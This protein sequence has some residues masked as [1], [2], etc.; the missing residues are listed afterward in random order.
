MTTSWATAHPPRGRHEGVLHR[1]GRD[2]RA[3]RHPSR[4]Q[5]AA[6][7]S[8]I[9][10]PSGCGKSTLLSILGL[11]DSPTERQLHA[12]TA[13]PV[14]EPHARRAGAHPQPGDRLHLPG[15]NLIGDL[16]VFENVELPLTYR[17][18]SAAERKERV[19]E[20]LER[21]A[22]RIAMKHFPAQLSG[23]QQQRVAVA[24]AL[25]GQP[26]DPARGRADGQ[27]RLASTARP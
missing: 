16:T 19:H 12:R 1:R 22:W 25:V 14:A 10:G 11:L 27:P 3:V 5:A 9:A 26:L 4:H 6:S 2:A 7:T 13:R 15:F 23:G 17:G 18:M 20:A 24:R 8:S 21:S